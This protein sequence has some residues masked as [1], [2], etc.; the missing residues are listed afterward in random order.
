MDFIYLHEF[1]V[2]DSMRIAEEVGMHTAAG[3]GLLDEHV[4]R[5]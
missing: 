4:S 1:S 3:P 5:V 2:M